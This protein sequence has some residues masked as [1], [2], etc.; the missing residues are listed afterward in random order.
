MFIKRKLIYPIIH[1]FMDFS[2]ARTRDLTVLPIDQCLLVTIHGFPVKIENTGIAAAL[3]AGAGLRLGRFDGR[4]IGSVASW[5][6]HGFAQSFK[7]SGSR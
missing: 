1:I 2:G 7:A 4:G 6:A 3:A 5:Q